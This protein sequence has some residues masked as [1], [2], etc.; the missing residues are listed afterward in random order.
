[1]RDGLVL[2]PKGRFSISTD[3][4]LMTIEDLAVSDNGVYECVGMNSE[5][6]GTC[7]NSYQLTVVCKCHV[8]FM[9]RLNNTIG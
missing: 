8:P 2:E 9:I 1:M 3:Q 4:L 5:G 7:H 6:E